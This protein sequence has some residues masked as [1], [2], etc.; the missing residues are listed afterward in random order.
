MASPQKKQRVEEPKERVFDLRSDTV[1]KPTEKM[2]LA[3]YEAEV[4]DDV[5]GDDPTVQKL[6]EIAAKLLGKEA[7]LYVTSGTQGNLISCMVHC[8]RRDSEAIV[9]D[10]CH[11][12]VYE[13][14]NM[15]TIGGIHVETVKNQPDGTLDLEELESKIRG[16]DVHCP[17]TR[18]V[19]FEN[20]AMKLST[21]TSSVRCASARALNFTSTAHVYSTPR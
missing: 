21:Q 18:L 11:I 4:G 19:C 2:R 20:T 14:G 6:E 5:F 7:A 9:G 10:Q 8:D 12:H 1:T 15:S 16:D 13:Q 3:A 17:V